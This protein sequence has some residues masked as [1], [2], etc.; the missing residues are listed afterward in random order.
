M[1]RHTLGDETLEGL[2]PF[3]NAF[4]VFKRTGLKRGVISYSIV[5][6]DNHLLEIHSY[7]KIFY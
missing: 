1:F 2:V 4:K 3:Q 6:R 5:S 7:K